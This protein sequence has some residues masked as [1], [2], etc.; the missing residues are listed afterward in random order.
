[1]TTT[2]DMQRA[3][4]RLIEA[5][6]SDDARIIPLADDVAY[7]SPLLPEPIEG[8]SAVRAHLASISPF[9]ARVELKRALFDGD[10][11]ALVMEFEAV[12]GVVLE[13]V[14]IL[15]IG[16]GRIRDF[17]VYFDTG[18]LLRGNR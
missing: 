13:G 17:R 14:E 6:N 9:I 1:M 8:E 10:S 3:V 4:A 12:N 15:R 7:S 18:P 11:A 2:H 16:G 5:I